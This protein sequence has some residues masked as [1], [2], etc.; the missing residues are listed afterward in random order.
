MRSMTTNTP[1]AFL[2]TLF[3]SCILLSRPGMAVD[4]AEERQRRLLGVRR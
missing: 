1:L 3:A 2:R 4:L